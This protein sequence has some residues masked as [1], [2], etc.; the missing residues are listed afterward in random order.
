MPEIPRWLPFCGTLRR[1]SHH[2]AFELLFRVIR[3][4]NDHARRRVLDLGPG[5]N[6]FATMLRDKR[7]TLYGYSEHVVPTPGDWGANA[8]ATGYWFLPQLSSWQ[9]P[10]ALVDFLASGEKPLCI[11][12][13]SMTTRDPAAATELVAR[14]CREARVRAVLL[15][16]WGGLAHADLGDDVLAL[17]GAPHDWLFPR[18]AGVI[19]HGGA[20]TTSAALRAGVPTTAATFI[21]DQQFWGR[22]IAALGCGPGPIPFRKL[23]VG[24]LARRMRALVDTP[25]YRDAALEIGRRLRGE[26]GAVRAAA[27][28]RI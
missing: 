2:A 27:A 1:A 6:G 4:A 10:R 22:R 5:T 24:E 13:G 26:N 12:F 11:G 7:L 25:A 18:V 14:A 20:G 15:T 3:R 19:H 21:A 23:R 9:P 17:E 8:Q 16:G 28:F